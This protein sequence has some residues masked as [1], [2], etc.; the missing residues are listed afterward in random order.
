MADDEPI[1]RRHVTNAVNDR[2][3]RI[4]IASNA[5]DCLL[6]SLDLDNTAFVAPGCYATMGFGVS[7]GLGGSGSHRRAA[8]DPGGRRRLPDDRL[9][10]W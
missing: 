7:A 5:D 1:S 6:T 4:P 2:I 10:A 3:G 9:G 8:T